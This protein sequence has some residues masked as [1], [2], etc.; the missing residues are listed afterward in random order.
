[1]SRVSSLKLHRLIHKARHFSNELL[2]HFQ[3]KPPSLKVVNIDFENGT[4]EFDRKPEEKVTVNF[5]YE[6]DD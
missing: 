1:M 4:V 6:K 3:Q 5:R 2:L